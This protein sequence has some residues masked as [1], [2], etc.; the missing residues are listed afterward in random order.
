MPRSFIPPRRRWTAQPVPRLPHPSW[1]RGGQCA[2]PVTAVSA[3]DF[4]NRLGL[5]ALRPSTA[6][7]GAAP[8]EM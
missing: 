4:W 6:G 2:V 8:P 3:A 7:R 1:A 5:L